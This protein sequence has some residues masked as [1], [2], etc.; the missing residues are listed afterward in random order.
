MTF[1]VRL[2]IDEAGRVGGIVERVRTGE[3]ERFHGIDGLAPVIARMAAKEKSGERTQRE[4]LDSAEG[5][6]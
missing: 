4:G 1:V 2:S 3:K 5:S 6:S